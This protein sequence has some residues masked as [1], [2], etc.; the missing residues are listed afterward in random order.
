MWHTIEELSFPDDVTVT[1][2]AVFPKLVADHYDGMCI[3]SRAFVGT[4]SSSEKRMYTKSIEIVWRNQA[5][6]GELGTVADTQVSACDLV[7]ND[8][9]AQRAGFGVIL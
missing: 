3:A 5:A 2:V 7:A 1:V 8:R 6:G 4:E 9:F